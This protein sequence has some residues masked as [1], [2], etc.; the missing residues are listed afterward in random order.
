MVLQLQV[1]A[2]WLFQESET[3]NMDVRS[4]WNNMGLMAK[5]VVACLFIMSAW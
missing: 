3:M 2:L 1:W 4:L 5:A